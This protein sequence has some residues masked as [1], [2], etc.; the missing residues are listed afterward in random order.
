MNHNLLEYIFEKVENNLIIRSIRA[1]LTMAIPI[2]LIGSM[3]LIFRTFS[4]GLITL[5]PDAIW[6]KAIVYISSMIYDGTFGVLSIFM[7]SFI[8]IS[9]MK[10]YMKDTIY[11]YGAP[12]TCNICFII[13]VGGLTTNFSLT[14]LGVKGLFTAIL[15]GTIGSYI[16]CKLSMLF[17]H[18]TKRLYTQGADTNF[19]N[20]MSCIKPIICTCLL[21]ASCNYIITILFDTSSFYHLLLKLSDILSQNMEPSLGNSIIFTLLT[22]VLWFFGIHGSNLLDDVSKQVFVPTLT[23][24]IEAIQNGQIPQELFTESFFNAFVYMGGCGSLICLFFALLFFSKRES[25]RYL[26]KVA[27]IPMLFNVNEIFVFG[28]PIVFNPLLFIPFVF[29]PI[30]LTITTAF[31]MYIGWLPLTIHAVEWTAPILY[32]GW[33]ATNSIVGCFVQIINITIGVLIY[34]PFLKL[35]DKSILYHARK[36]LTLL[37]QLLQEKEQN[38]IPVNLLDLNNILGETAKIIAMD[39]KESLQKKDINVYYQPQYNEKNCCIGAEA[40]LRWQHKEYGLIY[41]P[42][43]IKLADEMNILTELEEY[44]FQT[45][46]SDAKTFQQDN[47]SAH[48]KFSINVSAKTLINPSFETFLEKLVD[49]ETLQNTPLCIEITEQMTLTFDNTLTQKL[50]HIREMGFTLAID[51]FS[52]GNTSLKYLQSNQ[53][54]IVKLDGSLI[55]DLIDNSNNKEII[56]SI[57]YLANSLGFNVLAEYVEC[58]EQQKI[59]EEIGCIQYQGYLYGKAMPYHEFQSFIKK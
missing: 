1:G 11:F 53:F 14:C 39:L 44:I 26:T 48:L 37:I 6:L 19:N 22:N 17:Y 36:R 10:Q 40:L 43:I 2:L 4:I 52:M 13:M 24:N 47:P 7:V 59:L 35:Y 50:Q 46:V 20:S 9:F 51:D 27:A 30:I 49:K 25:N 21:F 29:T 38:N 15:V 3:S 8:S 12:I 32:S 5:Y 57:V 58:S 23:A 28:F 45:V 41:P 31:F 18:N 54:D 56:T 16:Y 55:K 34:L 42:L 33:I